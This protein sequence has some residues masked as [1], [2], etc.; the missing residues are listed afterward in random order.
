MIII[1]SQSGKMIKRTEEVSV[2]TTPK[3][4]GIEIPYRIMDDSGVSLGFYPTE[5]RAKEVM[6]MIE[7]YIR[8]KA[9]DLLYGNNEKVVTHYGNVQTVDDMIFTMPKE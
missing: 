4:Y 1:K 8:H 9:W 3:S 5:E 6:G 2:S 7:K